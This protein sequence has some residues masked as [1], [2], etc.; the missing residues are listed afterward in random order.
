MSPTTPEDVTGP[1]EVIEVDGDD[2]E[3]LCL[4]KAQDRAAAIALASEMSRISE[5]C[6]CASWLSG[7]AYDLW[8]FI[9]ERGPGEWGQGEVTAADVV[10]LRVLSERAGGWWHWPESRNHDTELTF[11][12]LEEWAAV[13]ERTP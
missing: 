1:L 11:Y 7:L 10:N 12:T 8:N 2:R 4:S 5:D 9:H 6:W 3:V 13:R